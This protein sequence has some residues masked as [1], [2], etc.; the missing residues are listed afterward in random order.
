MEQNI[1]LQDVQFP[2]PTSSLAQ[3]GQAKGIKGVTPTAGT[4]MSDEQGRGPGLCAPQCLPLYEGQELG[5]D[6]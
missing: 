5:W 4:W 3:P 2:Q 6:S 1:V